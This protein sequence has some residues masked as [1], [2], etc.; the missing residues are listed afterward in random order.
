MKIFNYIRFIPA[1]FVVTV[2]FSSPVFS[3]DHAETTVVTSSEEESSEHD[4]VGDKRDI[5]AGFDV[6]LPDIPYM[7]QE[8]IIEK[9]QF[10]QEEKP[11]D[12]PFSGFRTFIPKG[13]TQAPN[14]LIRNTIQNGR[15]VGEIARFSSDPN[16][17]AQSVVRIE[18][19]ELEHNISAKNWLLKHMLDYGYVF[20]GLTER[21]WNRAEGLG[22]IYNDESFD[23]KDRIVAQLNGKRVILLIYSS[24][25]F[26]W[27]QEKVYQA[28]VAKSFRM[29]KFAKSFQH[30]MLSYDVTGYAE[31]MYPANWKL[32]TLN[33]NDFDRPRIKLFNLDDYGDDVDQDGRVDEQQFSKG[34][35]NIQ[36]VVYENT[37]TS[38]TDEIEIQKELASDLG[39]EVT[40]K[41]KHNIKLMFPQSTRVNELDIYEGTSTEGNPNFEIWIAYMENDEAYYFITMITPNKDSR[42]FAWTENKSAFEGIVSSLDPI[43]FYEE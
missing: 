42:Y 38:I 8:E 33:Q 3:Q 37:G 24:P 18:A 19:Y 9:M 5:Y 43:S 22:V 36:V 26:L 35:I 29:L 39:I 6:E 14:S 34:I 27:D 21:D 30:E 17:L 32:G 11:S 28:T 41:L 23:Y 15:I 4:L 16:D 12:D 13:W 25:L 1:F 2:C 20:E 31:F 10:F 7:T 40:K